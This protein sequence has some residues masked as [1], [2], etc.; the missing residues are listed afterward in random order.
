MRV[1]INS[2]PWRASWA[3]RCSWSICH[4]S[5]KSNFFPRWPSCEASG[6]RSAPRSS[7]SAGCRSHIRRG[8]PPGPF[9]DK[10]EIWACFIMIFI[11]TFLLKLYFDGLAW[12]ICIEGFYLIGFHVL[13]VRLLYAWLT[14]I[15]WI[16]ITMHLI[17]NNK[18]HDC[19]RT[20]D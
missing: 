19:G 17:H 1:K 14:L 11:V 10:R 6:A 2:P 5:H 18:S 12:L 8:S 13:I 15:V 7:G 9:L 20:L 16:P 3:C 4:I